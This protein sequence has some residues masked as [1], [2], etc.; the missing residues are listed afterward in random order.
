MAGQ[1]G[2]SEIVQPNFNGDLKHG[3]C[4][5]LKPRKMLFK[6]SF[7]KNKAAQDSQQLTTN[8]SN[9]YLRINSKQTPMRQRAPPKK[10]HQPLHTQADELI[11]SIKDELDYF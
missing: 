6:A 7:L 2:F 5:V 3:S 8:P 4:K 1:Y 10:A 9:D 11:R